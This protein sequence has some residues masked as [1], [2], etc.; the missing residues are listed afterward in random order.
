MML[1][2]VVNFLDRVNVGFAALTMNRDLN[3]SPSVFGF[4]AGIFFIGYF[5]FHVPASVT[6]A[7]VG[8]QRGVFFI[9]AVWGVISASFAFV[10]GDRAFYALRFL[11]GVA[12]AGFYPGM[13]F[14]LTLWFPTSYR[15]RFTAIFSAAIP[16]SNII[17]GPLSGL[18]LG[19]DGILGFHGWQ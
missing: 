3:F 6:L 11:L 4:G 10:E 5:A 19:M 18:I 16:V 8:A 1:L 12:E 17:G 9:M 2:Y 14:Y 13:I 7:R 15:A